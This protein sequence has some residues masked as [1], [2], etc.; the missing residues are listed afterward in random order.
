MPLLVS[1][2]MVSFS[3]LKETLKWEEVSDGYLALAA[4]KEEGMQKPF[5]LHM[6]H[7]PVRAP[8]GQPDEKDD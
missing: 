8:R 5:S 3:D 2:F 6:F 4:G 7:Q 1:H